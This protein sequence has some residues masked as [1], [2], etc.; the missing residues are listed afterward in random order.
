MFAALATLPDFGRVED[1]A[2]V[3]AFTDDLR[4][5]IAREARRTLAA[6]Q[7]IP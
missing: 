6:L 7:R 5:T 3:A 4:P 1:I 2:A